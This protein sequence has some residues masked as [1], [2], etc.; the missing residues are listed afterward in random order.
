ME[1]KAN[2]MDKAD[3]RKTLHEALEACVRSEGTDLF[4]HNVNH[5]I[6]VARAHY[7]GWDADKEIET[8]QEHLQQKYMKAWE[9]WNHTPHRWSQKQIYK[10]KLMNMYATDMY[11]FIK[12]ICAKRG[13][14]LYGSTYVDTGESDHD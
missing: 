2:I 13:M 8:F 12:N 14:L 4:V 9:I 10:T 6:M 1:E 7:P 3:W 11:E 5:L